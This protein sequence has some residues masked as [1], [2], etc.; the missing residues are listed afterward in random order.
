MKVAEQR[1]EELRQQI[2][3]LRVAS[4]RDQT[5]HEEIPTQPFW[6]QPFCREID[7][8]PIPPNFREVIVEPFDGSQDPYA[9]LQAFET[10]MY[11]SG[12]N[13]RL[14]CKLFPGMLRRVAM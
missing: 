7:E 8:T 10:Q 14:S 4:E 3:A 9:H 6:G 11:I 12:G 13:D 5:T 2:A 1:E